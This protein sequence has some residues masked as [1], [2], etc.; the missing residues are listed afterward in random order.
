MFLLEIHILNIF[1]LALSC[2]EVRVDL[3]M[4][5]EQS[6]SHGAGRL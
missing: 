3:G 1:S 2:S 4:S 5:Q 6:V